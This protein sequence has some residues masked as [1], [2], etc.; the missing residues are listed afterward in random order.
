MGLWSVF[1]TATRCPPPLLSLYNCHTE[2]AYQNDKLQTKWMMVVDS[3]RPIPLLH[4]EPIPLPSVA[5]VIGFHLPS[6][7][8]PPPGR[9]DAE[10]EYPSIQGDVENPFSYRIGITKD[11][12]Q[13]TKHHNRVGWVFKRSSTNDYT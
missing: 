8:Q 3:F 12:N 13:R 6:R 10:A 4:S 7:H 5:V 11:K 1:P 2:L 9:V